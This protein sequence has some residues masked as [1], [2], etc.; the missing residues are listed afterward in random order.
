MLSQQGCSFPLIGFLKKANTSRVY[1]TEH[2]A[3]IP[4]QSYSNY[5]TT[6]YRHE[7]IFQE[8][9]RH[10]NDHAYYSPAYIIQCHV[11]AG[12]ILFESDYWQ[13]DPAQDTQLFY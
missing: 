8:C 2:D 13:G 9:A 3:R 4:V 5:F 1:N 12:E 11:D 6:D 7:I 10:F